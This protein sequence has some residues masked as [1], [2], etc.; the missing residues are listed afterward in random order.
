MMYFLY[1]FV[2]WQVFSVTMNRF[3]FGST[4]TKRQPTEKNRENVRAYDT[5]SAAASSTISHFE[6]FYY[7]FVSDSK[8]RDAQ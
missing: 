1:R 2:R 5:M 8:T 6:W 4:S 7:M 3:H